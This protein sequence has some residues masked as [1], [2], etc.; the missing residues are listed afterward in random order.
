M[1]IGIP[2]EVRA[3]EA[4]VGMTPAGVRELVRMGHHVWI[5]R[6]AGVRSGFADQA[7]IDA[8]AEL[9]YSPQE[10]YWRAD[11]VI[12]VVRPTAPEFAMLKDGTT[13]LGFLQLA[14]ARQ[15]KIEALLD[16]RITAIALE[17]I[18]TDTGDL[19]VI[20]AMSQIGGRMMPGLAARYLE[21]EGGGNGVL[22]AGVPGVPPAEVVIIGTGV[23]G[24]V[25]ARAFTR[26]GASV[27]ALDR[28]VQQLLATE[29]RCEP[30]RVATMMAHPE[31]IAKVIRFADV[32]VT[33]AGVSGQ[34]A[35]ILIDEQLLR[36]MRTGSLIM[37]VSINQG[38]CVATSRPTS[39]ADP[40]FRHAGIT[41]YCVPNIPAAVARTATHALANIT[42]PF[43]EHIVSRGTDQAIAENRAV[44]RGVWTHRGELV[45][46]TPA[47]EQE[48]TPWD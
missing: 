19:P 20:H 38:G 7:Y 3:G 8:G 26:V 18:A 14:S 6:G 16:K 23:F 11:L 41:H 21:I 32:V 45:Q 22:L 4:R 27:Y 34:R 39:H 5:E 36:E 48:V 10:V 17:S 15:Q 44:A 24:Q 40:V 25:A 47:H 35:P 43:I 28:Q 33:A 46:Y 29:R 12:K 31:N 2:R 13:L 42:W 37:D 9:V 30:G 1:K